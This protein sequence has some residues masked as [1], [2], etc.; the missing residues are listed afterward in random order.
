MGKINFILRAKVKLHELT[1]FCLHAC[2][3]YED[4]QNKL[5]HGCLNDIFHD[6]APTFLKCPHYFMPFEYQKVD[7]VL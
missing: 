7:H 3:D 4:F 1:N 5:C 2:S 6:E